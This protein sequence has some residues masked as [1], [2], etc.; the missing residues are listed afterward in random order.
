MVHWPL[1]SEAAGA[2]ERTDVAEAHDFPEHLVVTSDRMIQG[3]VRAGATVRS[4]GQ[5]TVLGAFLGPAIVEADAILMVQG[6]F[7][8][9]IERNDGALLLYGQVGF[10]PRA[11]VGRV[12]VGV[13]SLIT[14][15]RG[16]FRL[17]PDGDL[18]EV[19]GDQPAGSFNVQTDKV[20]VYVEEEGRF[21]AGRD[22]NSI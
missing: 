6:S 18:I 2:D 13:D 21:R 11:G 15:S 5:L 20:C 19:H 14:T 17:A 3:A 8:G 4:G 22:R 10:E 1:A 9:E 7:N 12:A 16:A